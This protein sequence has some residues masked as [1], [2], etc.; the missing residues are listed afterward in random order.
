M[1]DLPQE[2][3]EPVIS[4]P[5]EIEEL[6]RELLICFDNIDGPCEIK[7]CCGDVRKIV[8]ILMDYA[9]LLE[10]VCKEWNLQGYH[11]AYYQWYAQ[12][13]RKIAQKYQSGIRYDYDAAMKKCQKKRAKKQRNDDI[14]GEAMEMAFRKVQHELAE[15]KPGTESQKSSSPWEEDSF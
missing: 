12:E 13:A 9:R 8:D 6:G 1:L 7:T 11:Q 3:F 2:V 5:I 15:K 14:G 10:T 4:Q